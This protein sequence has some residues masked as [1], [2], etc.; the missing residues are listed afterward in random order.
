MRHLHSACST[1]KRIFH[2]HIL[3]VLSTITPRY[4][5]STTSPVPFFHLLER[6]KTTKRAGWKRFGIENAESISDHM[7]R[8]SI[9]TMMA[10]QINLLEA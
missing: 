7:Y 10:P 9:L 6:L 1:L 4:E 8:M 2:A 5:E 3:T